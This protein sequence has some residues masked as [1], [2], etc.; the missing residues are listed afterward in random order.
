VP[1][2][3][4]W[5]LKSSNPQ[6]LLI[7]TKIVALNHEQ[8]LSYELLFSVHSM[9]ERSATVYGI[10]VRPGHNLQLVQKALADPC[11]P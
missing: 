4:M 9:G 10:S 2:K 11:I 7:T 1:Y 8:N 3:L 6:N 5:Q